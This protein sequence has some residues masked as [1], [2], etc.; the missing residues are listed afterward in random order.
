MLH[1]GEAHVAGAQG[2]VDLSDDVQTLRA[3]AFDVGVDGVV[4]GNQG[5]IR[6]AKHHKGDE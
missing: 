4:V 5:N 2:S 1:P 6:T 3:G